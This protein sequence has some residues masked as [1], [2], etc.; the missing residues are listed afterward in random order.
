MILIQATGGS[1][2]FVR[3]GE[4]GNR[5]RGGNGG[6]PNGVSGKTSQNALYDTTGFNLDFLKNTGNYGAG[7]G[8][9][10]S[11]TSISSGGSGGYDSNYKNVNPNEILS[12]SVGKGG[13][14]YDHYSNGYARNGTS[15]FV[16]IAYGE[17][18]E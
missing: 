7:G 10:G 8:C 18:I 13:Q 3:G 5:G 16:L 6:T 17:G 12:I 2:G 11:Y 4:S 1:G 15:G 9:R 14:S